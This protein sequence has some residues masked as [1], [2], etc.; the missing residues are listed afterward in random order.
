MKYLK[1]FEDFIIITKTIVTSN[2]SFRFRYVTRKN[3]KNL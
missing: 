3:E 2:E 1:I